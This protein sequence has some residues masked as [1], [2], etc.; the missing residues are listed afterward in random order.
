MK[1]LLSIKPEYVEKILSGKKCYEFRKAIFKNKNV[2]TIIIYST[3]PVKKIVG[4]VQ[5]EG[6]LKDS[7]KN[8]WLKTQKKAGV[9]KKFF[10]EYFKEKEVA[11]AIKIKNP[12]KYEK[13]ITLSEYNENIKQAPQSFLYIT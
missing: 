6:I 13:E 10:S 11:Y 1:V 9:N 12:I 7:P 3:S 8:I 4:E 2:D 5:I